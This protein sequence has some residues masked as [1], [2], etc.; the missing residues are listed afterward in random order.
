MRQSYYS[1]ATFKITVG[2]GKGAK[3]SFDRNAVRSKR[4]KT[5]FV[6]MS[7]IHTLLA[8]A[9]ILIALTNCKKEEP[10]KYP[11]EP[12][13]L[14]PALNVYAE[15]KIR[16]SEGWESSVSTSGCNPDIADDN[17]AYTQLNY[18]NSFATIHLVPDSDSCSL[19]ANLFTPFQT[20]EVTDWTWDSLAFE[21]TYSEYNLAVGADF[22]ITLQYSNLYLHLNLAPFVDEL[23]APEVTDGLF[24]LTSRKGQPNFQINGIEFEPEFSESTGNEFSYTASGDNYLKL[25][26]K[27]EN[28]A[29]QSY[30]QFKFIRISRFGTPEA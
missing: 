25:Q 22:W 9:F 10:F 20:Q 28:L 16:E 29:D 27:S 5:T 26:L 11:D 3:S 19:E 24:K 4:S 15:R 30:L 2:A 18:V 23:I 1:E 17:L 8:G 14:P 6:F 7:K 13:V 12:A 21:Y